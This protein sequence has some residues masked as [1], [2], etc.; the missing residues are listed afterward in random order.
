MLAAPVRIL[1][2][3]GSKRWRRF[4]LSFLEQY[5]Q[6]R[7]IDEATNG[8]EVV[9]KSRELQPDLI[10]LDIVLPKLNGIEAARL[11]RDLAPESRILFLS[12]HQR[13]ELVQAAL[14]A[15]GSGYVLKS[16]AAQ[17]LLVALEAVIA[18]KQFIGR[19]LRV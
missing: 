5:P 17:E 1:I 12:E 15:G 6:F 8:L 11:I 18:N 3:D 13:P 2:A 4:F 14:N 10:L 7:V 9:G 16:D 19:R